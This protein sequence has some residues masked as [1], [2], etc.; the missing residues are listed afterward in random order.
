M[1][2]DAPTRCRHLLLYYAYFSAVLGGGTKE[3]YSWAACAGTLWI[4]DKGELVQHP[5]LPIYTATRNINNVL[6][7]ALGTLALHLGILICG[8]H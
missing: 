3:Y 6:F 1:Q 2:P 5:K 8:I 7:Y 4:S